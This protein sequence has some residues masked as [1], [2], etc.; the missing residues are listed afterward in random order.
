MAF[1]FFYPFSPSTV[2]LITLSMVVVLLWYNAAGGF[3]SNA[4]S[5][6]ILGCVLVVAHGHR[7]SVTL[8]IFQLPSPLALQTALRRAAYRL[9]ITATNED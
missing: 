3:Q 6:H 1:S 4:N 2:F 8:A 7:P 5:C 9:W